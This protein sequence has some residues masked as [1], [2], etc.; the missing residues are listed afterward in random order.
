[1]STSTDTSNSSHHIAVSVDRRA[2]VRYGTPADVSCRREGPVK[3]PGWPAT[4][5]DISTRGIGLFLRHRFEPGSQ[6]VVEIQNPG[7]GY[8]REFLVQ[9]VHA[10]PAMAAGDH[11]W[12][13]G[14]T[15][16]QQLTEEE[17]QALV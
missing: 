13:I 11:C 4:G 12:L 16:S 14:C 10:T 1:M 17:L 7:T 3:G 2:W 8:R 15:M 9:V 6:L 5:V